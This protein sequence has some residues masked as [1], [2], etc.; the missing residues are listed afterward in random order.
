[1]NPPAPIMHI[2]NG[3]IVFPSRSSRTGDDD[4]DDV[5][6]CVNVCGRMDLKG[7][8]KGRREGVRI[9]M[10]FTVGRGGGPTCVRITIKMV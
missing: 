8:E 3:L 7:R 6:V 9:E 2:V 10:K 5:I 1:M 4:D